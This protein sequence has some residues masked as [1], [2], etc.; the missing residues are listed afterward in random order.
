LQAE[1]FTIYRGPKAAVIPDVATAAD[2]FQAKLGET[3]KGD[4]D[5]DRVLVR[6]Y[7]E[8][9]RTNLIVYHEKRTKAELVFRGNRGHLRVTPTTFRPAQQ[10]FIS[11]DQTLGQVEIEAR[12]E[13][14]EAELRRAFAATCL[15]AAD[16]FDGADAAKRLELG[17][18]AEKAFD[19]SVDE[20]DTAR[21]VELH[22]KF[23]Q[24]HGPR[25]VVASKDVL[26]TLD[27]TE[28]RR[29]LSGAVIQRAVF[30]IAFR[31][32]KR[33]KRV[34]L[35]GSNSIKFKRATHADAIFRYLRNWKILL[36]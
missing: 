7:Q 13:K 21:L 33:G 34:E 24:K 4:K 30:N 17:K 11:Y 5:S 14:E 1:R 9:Q 2:R 29:A 6:H 15:G 19:M 35:S 3:F 20:V 23:P 27:L 12:S 36:G 22:F 18:I 25:F 16:F 8:G 32:E 28:L 31:G 10:D 26:E